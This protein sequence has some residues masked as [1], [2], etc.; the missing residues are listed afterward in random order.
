MEAQRRLLEELLGSSNV[1]APTVSMIAKRNI[2]LRTYSS[3]VLVQSHDDPRM[4]KFFLVGLCPHDLFMNTKHHLGDCPKVHCKP[5][6]EK[7]LASG[8]PNEREYEAMLL[9]ELENMVA[10]NDRE[11][12]KGQARVEEEEGVTGIARQVD[13]LNHPEVLDLSRAI[14]RAVALAEQAGEEGEV[15]KSAKAMDEAEELKAK[16]AALQL[17]LQ[18]VGPSAG[19]GVPGRTEATA[20][21]G[22]PKN[23]QKLRVCDVCASFLSLLDSDERLADHFGGRV[24]MGW[25]LIRGRVSELR[26]KGVAMAGSGGG[27]AGHHAYG[28][29]RGGGYGAGRAYGGGAHSYPRP[30]PPAPAPSYADRERERRGWHT[31]DKYRERERDRR[32]EYDRDRPRQ[33]EYERYREG[34]RDRYR[35]YDRERGRDAYEDRRRADGGGGRGERDRRRSRSR[36]RSGSRSRSRGRELPSSSSSHYYA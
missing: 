3:H 2:P 5:V 4:C 18:L 13:L 17:R 10:K 16:K 28:P 9:R 34:D 24:H 31:E 32:Q 14:E 19:A 6:V 33:H 12:A 25:G 21:A 27:T 22:E 8:K 11:V 26:K 1:N 20:K 15:E 29:G 36:S 7:W 35:D 23:K 30:A